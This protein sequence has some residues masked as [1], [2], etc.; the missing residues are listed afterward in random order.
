MKKKPRYLPVILFFFAC[1]FLLTGCETLR[2]KFTRKR[3]RIE[4]T[5]TIVIVPR[6]YSAHPFPNDV[7]YRQYFV[8]WK[9]W[10]Q[11][12]VSSLT[13]MENYKKIRSCADQALVNIKKMQTY[14]QEDKAQELDVYVKKTNDLL[15][16]IEHA[17]FLPPAQMKALRYDAERIL[18]GVNKKFDFSSMKDHLK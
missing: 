5:E 7:L 8:Y 2:K 12:L 6:D 10:N 17:K 13:D 14:L 1:V 11:E 18:S 15:L 16:R 3:K 9:S 4:S